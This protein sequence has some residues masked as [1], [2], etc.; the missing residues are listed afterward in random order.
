MKPPHQL[1]QH[2]NEK[3]MPC[4]NRENVPNPCSTLGIFIAVCEKAACKDPVQHLLCGNY[5]QHQKETSELKDP[6][7][8]LAKLPKKTIS[9]TEKEASLHFWSLVNQD[10]QCP[11]AAGTT[12]HGGAGE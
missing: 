10:A 4:P 1:P 2:L 5:H 9:P 7:Q 8:L 11:G 3:E 12:A 6:P